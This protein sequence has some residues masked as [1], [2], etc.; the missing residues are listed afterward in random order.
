ML[1]CIFW[2]PSSN[3]P[4]FRWFV[5]TRTGEARR[6]RRVPD[7]PIGSFESVVVGLYNRHMNPMRNLLLWASRNGSLERMV[8]GNGRF[9]GLARRFV[10]GE[11]EEEAIRVVQSLNQRGFQ[12]TLDFLGENTTNLDEARQA[13]DEYLHLLDVIHEHSLQANI[14][15]KLT[16]LGLDLGVDVA[17]EHA[18]AI[19][20]HAHERENSVE[21]D[22]EAS[23]Y[24]EDTL[25]IFETLQKRYGNLGIALQAYLYRTPG[26][27]RRIFQVGGKVRVVKGAYNEPRA[28]AYQSREEIRRA[29]GRILEQ[30]LTRDAVRA[31][32]RTAIATH[33]DF[34]IQ[35]AR[36]LIRRNQIPR[37]AYEFQFLYGV[38][39]DVQEA[40]VQEA[41][42]RLYVPFGTHWYPYFMRRLA[43]RPANLAFFLRALAGR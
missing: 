20:R 35:M 31:G 17:L 2:I 36:T 27:L 8:V 16:Q 15:I 6:S 40:L 29:F 33:D 32:V 12:V 43:E 22:M 14:S 5:R 41:P 18:E 23:A 10:A 7:A 4:G 11:T 34:L 1:F 26:D 13:R 28:I 30:L 42:V 37:E 25:A 19:A 24:V 21:V 39:R 38:R 9:S 3:D